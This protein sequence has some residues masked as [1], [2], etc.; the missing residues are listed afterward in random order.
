MP[1]ATT[2]RAVRARRRVRRAPRDR[3]EDGEGWTLLA[4]SYLTL[5]RYAEAVEAYRQAWRLAGEDAHL[6]AAFAEALVLASDGTVTP[7][8]QAAVEASLARD[9]TEP[10]ARYYR[11]L[12]AAQAGDLEAA[13]AQW[14]ALEADSAPDAPWLPALRTRIAESAAALGIETEERAPLGPSAED[15]DAASTMDADDR[16]AMI[17]GMVTG[18]AERIAA[19]PDD[20]DGWLMLARSY[21]VLE[22]P[23]NAA[24]AY[25]RA[26]ALAPGDTTVLL[27]YGEALLAAQGPDQP[28]SAELVAVLRPGVDARARQSGGAVVPRFGPRSRPMRPR[29]RAPCGGACW[30]ACPRARPSG[31]RSKRRFKTSNPERNGLARDGEIVRS[32]GQGGAGHRRVEGYRRRDRARAWGPG[33][34][35][36][37]ALQHRPGRGGGG[38]ARHRPPRGHL[39][40]ADF[41][42]DEQL[43]RLWRDA[44]AWRGRIDVLINNAEIMLWHGGFDADLAAW[45]EVWRRTL[46]VNGVAMARLTRAAVRYF[47]DRG[48]GI[49]VTISSQVAHRGVTNPDTAQYAASKAAIKAFTQSIASG[50]ARDGVLAYIIAPGVVRTQMSQAFARTQGGEDAVTESLAMREWVPPEEVA[51]VAAFLAT[52]QSRH[53]T[54]TTIDV[55]GAS[56][57]R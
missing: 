7:E 38:G 2:R 11:A 19:E 4:R 8:A 55:T 41:E 39:I 28:L 45:D 30:L 43:D 9:S 16:T 21:T 23:R 24:D 46:R 37:G 34:P 20:L 47:R 49:V 31:L 14:T 22:E 27:D 44:L 51:A 52:G 50:Y 17:R 36:G 29:R 5:G 35:C 40:Q 6:A 12:G 53:A 13:L 15:I 10:R 26:A 48:G 25:A 33:R 3:A 56:Y 42:H 57:I 1:T 32:H 18:L 54:G